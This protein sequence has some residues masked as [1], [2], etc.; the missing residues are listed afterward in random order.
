VQIAEQEILIV[1]ASLVVHLVNNARSCCRF[2]LRTKWPQ[3]SNIIFYSTFRL[4]RKP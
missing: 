1:V 3:L 2:L 4:I